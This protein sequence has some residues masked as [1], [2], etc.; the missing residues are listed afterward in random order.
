[1]CKLLVSWCLQ[2]GSHVVSKHAIVSE[3]ALLVLRCPRVRSSGLLEVSP[4]PTWHR[5]AVKT[6]RMASACGAFVGER[7][8][9]AAEYHSNDF[10]WEDLRAEV[11]ALSDSEQPNAS[12]NSQNGETPCKPAPDLSTQGKGILQHCS[13]VERSIVHVL[14]A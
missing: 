13:I 3:S 2:T 7:T 9:A 11:E 8:P 12:T 1:M 10:D 4:H 6:F 5:C 14:Q